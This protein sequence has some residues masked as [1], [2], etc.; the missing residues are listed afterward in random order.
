MRTA[1]IATLAAALLT[2]PPA[3]LAA[4][5]Q[6]DLDEF[7]TH[8]KERF[9]DTPF[10][11]YVNGIYSIDAASREQWEAIEEFPPYETAIDEGESLWSQPFANGKTYASCFGRNVSRIRAKYPYYDAKRDEVITLELA[12][13]ECRQANGEKPLKYKK[14][15]LAALSAYIAYQGRDHKIN[16]KIDSAGAMKWYERGRKQFYAKQGQL[17][18]SCADCHKTNA[19]NYVRADRLS[20]ALGQPSHF[21]VYRSKWGNLGTL[22]RRYAGCNSQ[23]R[24]KPHK[25]QS[26][27]Y[28]AL[29]FF[30]T[31]MANGLEW[32]GP[33]ARK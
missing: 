31:Y 24:A 30:H 19:G 8:F 22:H 25:A 23:V 4:A 10:N 26:P 29:E 7:R 1:F 11:D 6:A 3:I 9:P 33:G 5:P 2:A 14:G 27:E 13:N 21:P 20:P 15:P 32:N 16:V 18:L 17:N 12:L 28:R